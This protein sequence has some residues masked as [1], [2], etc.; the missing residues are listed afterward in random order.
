MLY[1]EPDG[2]LKHEQDRDAIAAA[3]TRLVRAIRGVRS[4]VTHHAARLLGYALRSTSTF[5]RRH[6]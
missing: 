1:L 3:D 2:Q 6:G 5:L 4:G